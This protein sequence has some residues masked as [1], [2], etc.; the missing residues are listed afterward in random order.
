MLNFTDMKKKNL[1]IGA[2]VVVL[3]LLAFTITTKEN[4]FQ[5]QW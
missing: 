4:Q 5:C 1:L 2:G 3:G